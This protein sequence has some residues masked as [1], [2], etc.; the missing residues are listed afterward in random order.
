MYFKT[1]LPKIK[2]VSS[3]AEFIRTGRTETYEVTSY[4]PITWVVPKPDPSYYKPAPSWITSIDQ[5][6]AYREFDI[7]KRDGSNR[8]IKEPVPRLKTTQYNIV[9]VLRKAGCL[10]TDNAH[11]FVKGRCTRTS[12]EVHKAVGS[13]YFLKLDIKNFFPSITT[14]LVKKTLRQ[15]V[16]LIKWTDEE[17]DIVAKYLTDE[18]GHCTQGCK[19]TPFI[20]NLVLTEF[21]YKLNRYCRERGL[22]YTR[23]A[24]DILIGSPRHINRCELVRHIKDY[25]P[26]ELQINEEK[27]Q[28]R[29][30]YHSNF[31]LGACYNQDCNIT[32]GHN[33][34]NL[35]KVVNYKAGKGELSLDD[36][37]YFRHYISYCR[38]V[39][40][41][42]NWDRFTNLV[43]R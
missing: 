29:S 15:Q 27:T 40:P 30:C 38:M 41:A 5:P 32:V 24:D 18:T 6:I 4:T 13:R 34:K 25:L 8:H 21:D 28:K 2:T 37:E 43:R 10:E 1:Y 16:C 36:K 19:S 12:L 31:L 22:C 9:N 39:E 17:L 20:A 11:G 33:K 35:L 23:Y 42:Y 7:P 26:A 14:E 3:D